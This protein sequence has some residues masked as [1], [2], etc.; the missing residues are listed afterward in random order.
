MEISTCRTPWRVLTANGRFFE[1]N[2]RRVEESVLS[3]KRGTPKHSTYQ[4]LHGHKDASRN[5]KAFS[6]STAEYHYIFIDFEGIDS[7]INERFEQPSFM[8]FSSVEQL[9]LKAVHGESYQMEMDELK[10]YHKMISMS[11]R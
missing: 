7:A 2:Y 5:T 4:Y 10:N 1:E 9:L 6:P 11:R 8:F 3:R